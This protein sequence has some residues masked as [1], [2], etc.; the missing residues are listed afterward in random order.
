M[1]QP[2]ATTALKHLP[3]MVLPPGEQNSVRL[4]HIS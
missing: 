4:C 2:E 1:A 3:K